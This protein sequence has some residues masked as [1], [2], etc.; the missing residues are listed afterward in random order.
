MDFWTFTTIV[1]DNDYQLTMKLKELPEDDNNKDRY[2][3][4]P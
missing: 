1:V 3:F 2:L 4:N